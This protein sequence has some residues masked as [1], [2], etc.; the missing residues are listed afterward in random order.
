[1][2]SGSGSSNSKSRVKSSTAAKKRGKKKDQGGPKWVA[3]KGGRTGHWEGGD[4]YD[5]LPF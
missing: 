3:D 5:D 2:A 1:M 4:I